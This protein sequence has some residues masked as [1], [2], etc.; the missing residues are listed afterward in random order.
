[1]KKIP[2]SAWTRLQCAGW[3]QRRWQH[4]L[5][6][7]DAD[8]LEI[9]ASADGAVCCLRLA[10]ET[11]LAALASSIEQPPSTGRLDNLETLSKWLDEADQHNPLLGWMLA[12]QETPGSFFRDF[13]EVCSILATDQ[14]LQ[15]MPGHLRDPLKLHEGVPAQVSLERFEQWLEESKRAFQHLSEQMV[16]Y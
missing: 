16:E 15:P 3:H 12:S 6:S 2:A 5:S 7:S 8:P 10:W 11:V 4:A 14:S 1:M 9:Q 13:S